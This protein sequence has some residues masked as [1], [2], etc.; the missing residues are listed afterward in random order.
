MELYEYLIGGKFTGKNRHT[1]TPDTKFSD[2]C[3]GDNLYL[4]NFTKDKKLKR[5]VP[6]KVLE[7]SKDHRRPKNLLFRVKNPLLKREY[8]MTYLATKTY[9]KW[10]FKDLLCICSPYNYEPN[11]AVKFF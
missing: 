11:E 7:I 5:W 2:V 6:V 9:H 4:W 10:V 3:V 8:D 1:S